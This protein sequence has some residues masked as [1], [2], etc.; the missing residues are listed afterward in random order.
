MFRECCP[1]SLHQFCHKPANTVIPK[2]VSVSVSLQSAIMYDTAHLIIRVAEVI[3]P[4]RDHQ[5]E[6]QTIIIL[7]YICFYQT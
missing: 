1:V 5:L 2:R 6:F 3:Q 4:A 7:F